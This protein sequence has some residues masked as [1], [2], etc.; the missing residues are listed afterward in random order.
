MDMLPGTEQHWVVF[1]ILLWI[2]IH[3][4]CEALS[5]H[6]CSVGLNLS[7]EYCPSEFIL[8]LLSAVT[9]AIN[10]TDLI[11]WQPRMLVS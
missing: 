6:V 3:L 4:H 2:V 8:R 7:R 9:S 11:P 1:F 5:D 10:T